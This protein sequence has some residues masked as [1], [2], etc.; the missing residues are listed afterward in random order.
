M[1]IFTIA[2]ILLT[3]SGCGASWPEI[4]GLAD[5]QEIQIPTAAPGSVLFQ[6]TMA[7]GD[8]RDTVIEIRGAEALMGRVQCQQGQNSPAQCTDT[9]A[10]PQQGVS[11]SCSTQQPCINSLIIIS[12]RGDKQRFITVRIKDVGYLQGK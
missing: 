2:I 3:L 10:Y 11:R 5:N 9:T 4:A 7:D 12:R 8:Y 1:R 6:A